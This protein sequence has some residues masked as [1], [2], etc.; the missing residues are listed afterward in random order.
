MDNAVKY[1]REFGFNK[2]LFNNNKI[3]IDGDIM[4]MGYP[5]D[6]PID[7]T[8]SI[9]RVCWTK[10]YRY[11]WSITD[12]SIEVTELAEDLDG[13]NNNT[14]LVIDKCGIIF[15][16]DIE[17]NIFDEIIYTI[18]TFSTKI[19]GNSLR[20]FIESFDI[21]DAEYIDE[22]DNEYEWDEV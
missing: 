13:P 19:N 21:W 10:L 18:D 6:E 14:V 1:V 7:I 17:W 3:S 15:K 4:R 16:P 12:T 11:T 20:D 2:V 9:H 8:S 22:N 5:K